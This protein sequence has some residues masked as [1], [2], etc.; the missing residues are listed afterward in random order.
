MNYIDNKLKSHYDTGQMSIGDGHL[1]VKTQDFESTGGCVY[2]VHEDGYVL[3]QDIEFLRSVEK[4]AF[5]LVLSDGSDKKDVLDNVPS[6][7]EIK[8]FLD[9]V[10]AYGQT[11]FVTDQILD[12]VGLLQVSPEDIDDVKGNFGCVVVN[13]NESIINQRDDMIASLFL[14]IIDKVKL[15]GLVFIPKSTCRYVPHGRIGVEALIK[16]LDLELELPLHNL[17]KMVIAS[18]RINR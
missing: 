4:Y 12:D 1:F 13:L 17:P 16:V 2:L 6:V 9:M 10:S 8:S 3:K 18:K 5:Q 11:L 7:D 14:R 15:G